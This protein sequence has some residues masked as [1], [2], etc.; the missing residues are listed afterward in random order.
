M[1][2]ALCSGFSVGEHPACVILGIQRRQ[3]TDQ[4][5]MSFHLRGDVMHLSVI[6]WGVAAPTTANHPLT[7]LPCFCLLGHLFRKHTHLSIFLARESVCVCVCYN[8]LEEVRVIRG[9]AC[10]K[11][12]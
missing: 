3:E 6:L 10:P 12:I 9:G 8:T 11:D 7:S 5:G 1:A 4:F 2:L